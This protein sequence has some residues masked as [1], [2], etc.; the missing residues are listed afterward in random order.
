LSHEIAYA[1]SRRRTC[2]VLDDSPFNGYINTAEQQWLVHWPFYFNWW[3][4][5]YIRY[6][7][8]GHKRAAAPPSPLPAVPNV[9][10]YSST[11]SVPVYYYSM[12]HYNCLCS[13]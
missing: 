4:G 6:S 12:W 13:V 8:E 9:T 2:T 11:T 7:E 1:V 5:C 3:V 10:A